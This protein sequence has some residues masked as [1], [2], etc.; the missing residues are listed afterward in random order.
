MTLQQRLLTNARN[1]FVLA[2]LVF[3]GMYF[4]FVIAGDW[5]K[6]GKEGSF[7]AF[8]SL[9]GAG[10]GILGVA[11]GVA[12]CL[13]ALMRLAGY[14]KVFPGLGVEQLT[15]ALGLFATVNIFA[16]VF[17]WLPVFPIK[18]DPA[19]T[20]WA[21]V[22]AYWPASFIPQLGILT[23]ARTRPNKGIKPL[24]IVD[25][26][27]VS[28][29]SLVA[30]AGV[31]AFPFMTWIKVTKDA[32]TIKLSTYD[33]RDHC[34]EL[35]DICEE[36]LGKAGSGPRLGYLLLIIGAV[37]GFAAL[38]R[39]RPKGLAEPG[40]NMLL[41]HCLFGMGLTAFLIPLA[42]IITT[43]QD[44]RVEAGIGLW[45]SLASGALMIAVSIYENYRRGAKA[46]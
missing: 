39:L 10:F 41:S 4:V 38:M 37:V 7:D 30:A 13:L 23:V 36:I 44:D 45:L 18:K 19:G 24:S 2:H 16:F 31:I 46:A 3:A 26:T 25:R 34:K 14:S 20:G 40:P 27:A 11:V 12:L 15:L 22:A 9:G 43:A 29:L 5:A 33:G 8:H 28:S 6:R 35:G 21:L 42:M 32:A 17:G 1:P